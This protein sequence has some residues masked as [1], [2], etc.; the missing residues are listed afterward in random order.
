M[1]FVKYLA[2]AFAGVLMASCD[3]DFNDWASPI[4]NPEEEAITIPGYTATA[5]EEMSKV[6][7]GASDHKMASVFFRY[8]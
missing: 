5:A 3:E 7:G 6:W 1:K 8:G 2:I 4:T